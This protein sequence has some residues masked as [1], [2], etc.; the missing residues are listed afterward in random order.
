M[1]T[2]QLGVFAKFTDY[3]VLGLVVI[4]LGYV[5]WFLFKKNMDEKDRLQKIMEEKLKNNK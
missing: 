4:A 1:S 3:G 5:G 2:E